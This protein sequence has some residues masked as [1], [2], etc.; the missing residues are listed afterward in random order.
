MPDELFDN[1]PTYQTNPQ[2]RHDAAGDLSDDPGSPLARAERR[3][4]QKG[5]RD[6][7]EAAAGRLLK[8]GLKIDL[9]AEAA[10]LGEEYLAGLARIV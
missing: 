8:K 7:A 4:Y 10:G 1:L 9:V 6:Q 2:D 5:R 3:G